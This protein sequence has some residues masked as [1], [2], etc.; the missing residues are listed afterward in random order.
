[1]LD[2]D[3][4]IE[5]SCPECGTPIQIATREKGCVLRS[6][7]PANAVVWSGIRYTGG[8]CASS[9]CKA[10]LFFCT[11]EHLATRRARSD[12]DGVGFRLS[13]GAALQVGKAIF[14]PMLAAGHEADAL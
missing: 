5:S 8:C 13:V 7:M 11:D 12:P 10:K 2:C 3:T 6:V 1:M 14:V 9:G 4:E